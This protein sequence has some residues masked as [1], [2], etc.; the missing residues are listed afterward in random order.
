MLGI[1][2]Y[3]YYIDGKRVE[4]T[5]WHVHSKIYSTK[6]TYRMMKDGKPVSKNG[7]V[8]QIKFVVA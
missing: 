2:E 4:E 5:Y 7:H 8:Y 3:Y 1:A 6:E